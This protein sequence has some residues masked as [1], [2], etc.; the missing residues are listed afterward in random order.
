VAV[1]EEEEEEEEEET[2]KSGAGKKGKEGGATGKNETG[3]HCSQDINKTIP[4]LLFGFVL[5][6]GYS[7]L[8]VRIYQW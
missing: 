7:S 6:L 8:G 3:S 2:D 4:Q 5:Y 1:K